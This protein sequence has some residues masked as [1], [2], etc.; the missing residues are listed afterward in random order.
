MN[1]HCSTPISRSLP[2]AGWVVLMAAIG[3]LTLPACASGSHVVGG[4]LV[5][6]RSTCVGS[7][8]TTIDNGQ[9]AV[10]IVAIDGSRS[11]SAPALRSEYRQTSLSAVETAAEDQAA[12]RIVVFGASGVGARVIFSDSF[13]PVSTVAAFNLAARNR[14]L[15]LA[16]KALAAAFA[17]PTRMAG[18]DV[19]G[20][21]GEQIAWGR[22][23]ARAHGRVSLKVTTD[24]CQA[25]ARSGANAHLTDICHELRSGRKP[26]WILKHHGQEFS[27]GPA[28][29]VELTMAGLGI[30]GN[31][32]AASTLQAQ[33][34]V[35][36]WQLVCHRSKAVCKIG[37][38]VS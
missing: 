2:F 31:Q 34:L 35:A 30:G 33:K 25:P 16:K 37:S 22:S 18:T 7:A 27:L 19:A 3:L 1:A 11:T 12:V 15:C 32:S 38:A 10:D 36:F 5:P 8:V 6:T 23:V 20:V 24:G 13:V 4:S 29:G 17:K 9:K 28:R 14:L 26:A 21:I